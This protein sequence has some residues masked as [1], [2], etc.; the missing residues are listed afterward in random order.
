MQS[1]AWTPGGSWITGILWRLHGPAAVP[2]VQKLHPQHGVL[3]GA[4]SWLCSQG[5]LGFWGIVRGLAVTRAQE[6]GLLLLQL[7]DFPV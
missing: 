1:C 6:Q 4:E 3:G 5:G 2:V 7:C